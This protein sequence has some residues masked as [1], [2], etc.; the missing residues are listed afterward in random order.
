MA[1]MMRQE[2]IQRGWTQE[3]VAQYAGIS[4]QMIHDIEIARR[5]PSYEVLV[6]L[7]A[8]FGHD[9]PR[10]LFGAATPEGKREPEGNPAE[11]VP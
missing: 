9:D 4:K 5:K 1:T 6:K 11:N 3:F 7:L 8:L 2:R 10:T